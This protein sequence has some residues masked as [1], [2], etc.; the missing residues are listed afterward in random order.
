MNRVVLR[1]EAAAFKRYSIT[2][3][4]SETFDHDN[5]GRD[6]NILDVRPISDEFDRG[7]GSA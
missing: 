5:V 6:V 7:V 1:D 2:T 3:G 4:D